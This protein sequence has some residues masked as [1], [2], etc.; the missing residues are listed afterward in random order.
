VDIGMYNVFSFDRN[1]EFEENGKGAEGKKK[2]GGWK[3]QK[4][5]GILG[6]FI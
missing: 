2:A 6:V 4:V 5:D 1:R 3:S